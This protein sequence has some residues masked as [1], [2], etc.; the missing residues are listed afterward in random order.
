LKAIGAP[1]LAF[2]KYSPSSTDWFTITLVGR[3]FKGSRP[4]RAA[5]TVLRLKIT[6]RKNNIEE[7]D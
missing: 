3:V 1:A 2:S 4:I 6:D 7:Y 5:S